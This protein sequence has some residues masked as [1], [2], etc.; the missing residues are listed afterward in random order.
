MPYIH[1]SVSKKITDAEQ[2]K[3]MKDFGR[4][5]AALPGK[6]EQ[7]LMVKISDNEKM[8]FQGRSEEPCAIIEVSVYGTFS[9]NE[10][11]QLTG[12]LTKT[13]SETV[14]VPQNRIYIKY[15]ETSYWGWDGSN[16]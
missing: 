9:S 15:F 1:V 14:R 7:W 4:E 2:E 5:I 8:C 16:F 6:S 11:Q 3:I 10:Y 12:A 13:V